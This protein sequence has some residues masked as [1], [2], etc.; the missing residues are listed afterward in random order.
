ME[1]DF[2]YWASS[3]EARNMFRDWRPQQVAQ[4][5]GVVDEAQALES[6]YD[7]IG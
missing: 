3:V 1:R 4:E 2:R 5:R 6:P 7:Y